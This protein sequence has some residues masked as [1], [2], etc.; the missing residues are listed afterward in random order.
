VAAD[1][2]DIVTTLAC[3]AA[4]FWVAAVQAEP[5]SVPM[6]NPTVSCGERL[7]AVTVTVPLPAVL[8][9]NEF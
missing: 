7:V 4:A 2:T 1:D 3:C 9:G 5:F 6:P 8:N